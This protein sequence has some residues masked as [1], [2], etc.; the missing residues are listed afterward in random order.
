MQADSRAIIDVA[1]GVIVRADGQVLLGRRPAGKPWSGW[2]ELPGGKIEPGE[3]VLAALTRELD[4]EIG[5]RVTHATTWITFVH[6]YPTSTVRLH[7]CRVSSWEGEPHGR[8]N[9]AL[10]WLPPAEALLREDL[11]P[12]TYPPLRWLQL[13]RCYAI[14]AIGTPD[15]LEGPHGWLAR[16]DASLA[17]GVRLV[18]Y[19]EPDWPQGPDAPALYRIFQ[20]VLHRCR[21]AQARL[22]VNSVHPNDWWAEADGVHLRA[23]DAAVLD[24]RPDAGGGNQLDWVGVSAHDATQ[25]AQARAIGADFAVLG[26]VCATASHPG[27]PGMGWARFAALTRG[28]N[29]PVYALGGQSPGTLDDAMRHGAHGV[30]AIRGFAQHAPTL[31]KARGA[32]EHAE[33]PCGGLGML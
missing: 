33:A 14:S 8:E 17:A 5:I 2:W 21:A 15:N 19:R 28:A 26:P 9:Q 29:L 4:E 23:V 10:C 22:L 3:T 16:L 31:Q 13:P 20:R 25:L 18:Q 7:F 1:G 30:A 12:A 24:S 27:Q 6:A 11:L 32:I